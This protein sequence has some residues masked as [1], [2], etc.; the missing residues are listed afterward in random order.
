MPGFQQKP[1]P[2]EC[3]LHMRTNQLLCKLWLPPLLIN[4]LPCL[5]CWH[6]SANCVA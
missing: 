5:W 1:N 2:C 6:C 4:L 3:G